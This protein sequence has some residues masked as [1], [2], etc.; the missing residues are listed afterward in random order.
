MKVG[1]VISSVLLRGMFW[2]LHYVHKP[3]VAYV[4]HHRHVYISSA[5]I[6]NIHIGALQQS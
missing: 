5:L 4:R 6:T 1:H 2:T 3:W